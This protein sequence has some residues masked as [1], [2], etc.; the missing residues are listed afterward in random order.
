MRTPVPLLAI[1]LVLVVVPAALWLV[2][3]PY[4]ARLAQLVLLTVILTAS[5]NLLTGTAGLLALDTAVYYGFGAYTAAILSTQFGTGFLAE[6]VIVA[7]A[8]GVIGFGIGFALVRLASIF[9]AVAT[10]GLAIS[11]HTTVLNWGDLTRGPM[12]IRNIPS[13]QVFGIN[14]STWA[15]TYFVTALVCLFALVIIHRLTHSFYGN[16]VRAVREDE[17]A[18]RSM[19]LKPR[20]IKAQVYA[21]HAALM[22]LA[23]VL[24]AHSNRFIGPDNFVL[25]ESALVLT[26]IVVGGLGSLPGAALGAAISILVPEFLREF[27]QLRAFAFGVILFAVILFL[28]RGLLS[29]VWALRWARRHF[30]GSAWARRAAAP[31]APPDARR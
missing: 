19:G 3:S 31:T 21:V 18:A 13:L 6:M 17:E 16:A 12:G 26:A 2:G 24:Y 25:L 27:G 10:M 14:L 8:A 7:I 28:P 4:I 11:F 1:G 15:G 5:L 29:E 22:G 23:G 30:A 20:M 9:F